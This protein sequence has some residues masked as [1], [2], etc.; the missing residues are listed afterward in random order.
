[1]AIY[2]KAGGPL[3]RASGGGL[4]GSTDCCCGCQCPD[5]SPVGS[6]DITVFAECVPPG[7]SYTKHL[8]YDALHSNPPCGYEWN[9]DG[10][11]YIFTIGCGDDGLVHAV[12]RV[13]GC[14]FGSNCFYAI[15]LADDG[16]I[17][18]NPVGLEL[19]NTAGA[20]SE[21]SYATT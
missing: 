11:T 10:R 19:P 7:G 13:P 5:C 6:L 1:M 2:R 3:L 4:A 18:C 16:S 17:I 15:D 9:S 21:A 8:I 12:L 14:F 20:C